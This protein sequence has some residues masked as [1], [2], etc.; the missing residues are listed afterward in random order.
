MLGRRE[1]EIY[2]K[3]SLADID[4]DLIDF[5][6]CLDVEVQCFQSNTEGALVDRLQK[7]YED[8]L[9]GI[10]INPAA[11]G[12]TSIALRDALLAVSMP[13][14]EVHLSNVQK[15][16]SFRQR[17]LISDIALGTIMGFGANSYKLGLRALQEYLLKV[18]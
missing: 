10:V 7:A 15:R 11:Y 16:E 18:G 8:K 5:G 1:P 13:F 17:S 14:V 9:S 4:H 12:H 2:G 3:E 6:K